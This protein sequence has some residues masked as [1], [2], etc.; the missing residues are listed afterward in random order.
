M[1]ASLYVVVTRDARHLSRDCVLT[2]TSL[3]NN[4]DNR[5]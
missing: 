4:K 5:Q 1:F 3:W 2:M